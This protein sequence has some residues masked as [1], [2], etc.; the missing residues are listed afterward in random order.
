ME[1]RCSRDM[2]APAPAPAPVPATTG[3]AT[4]GSAAAAVSASD[5]DMGVA[6][7]PQ[8]APSSSSFNTI[9]SAQAAGAINSS[10][11]TDFASYFNY[12]PG[13]FGTYASF[14]LMVI[15]MVISILVSHYNTNIEITNWV[16]DCPSGYTE[17]CKKNQAVLRVSF[18]LALIF[19]IQLIGTTIRTS[20]FDQYWIVKFMLFGGIL[21]GFFYAKAEVFDSNGYAWIARIA[22]FFFVI[23]Q[24]VILIDFAYTWNELWKQS[25]E[26]AS[27]RQNNTK[28]IALAVASILAIM[29]SISAMGVM[30]HY[31][32]GCASTS[33]IISLTLVLSL[34]AITFQL[35][36][37]NQGSLLTSAI[38]TAYSTYIC[39]SAISLN[40]KREC[41]PTISTDYQNVTEGV[42]MTIL[43]LSLI[44][45]TRN[46]I[47]KIP[48]GVL[49][50]NVDLEDARKSYS[51]TGLRI[52]LQEC[53]FVFALV[54]CYYAMVTPTPTPI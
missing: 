34:L 40:P 31:F 16:T 9:R 33:T 18:A 13:V 15:G 37:N 20:F 53:S 8:R 45:T 49:A 5:V 14:L 23:L 52:I 47:N 10:E 4:A 43:V 25:A 41:N 42:G 1:R 48:Q 17:E 2:S 19:I 26:Y 44:W 46:T 50:S 35:F 32:A 21:A 36:I 39:Y 11:S 28:L 27:E 3:N 51:T 12:P 7:G 6:P 24:Q 22:G 54:S 38:M 29:G 30:F